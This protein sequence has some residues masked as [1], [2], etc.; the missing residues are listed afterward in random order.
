MPKS[1]ATDVEVSI[2]LPAYNEAEGLPHV[3]KNLWEALGK[4][5]EIIVIDDGSTDATATVAEQHFCRVVQHK[6][7]RGKG[8]A[9]RT[10]I[11]HAQGRYTIVM[12]ADGTY[13]ASAIPQII[14]LL[15]DCDMVR[16]RRQESR[17][18]IPRINRFG[19]WLFDR[20]LTLLHGLEGQDHLSGLY[21]FRREALEKLNLRSRGFDIEAEISVQASKKGLRVKTL[22]IRYQARFGEKKLR[23][24]RDGWVILNR[25]FAM[26][27]LY[28]PLLVFVVPSLLLLGVT[29]AGT[30][31]LSRGPFLITPYLGLS[32]HSFILA[33]L[34]V[35]GAFQLFS[36]G[37]T[38]SLYGVEFGYRVPKW[39]L[40]FSARHVR[41]AGVVLGL[42]LV[43]GGAIRLATMVYSWLRSGAGLYFNTHE[44]T[45]TATGIVWGLQ[46]TSTALFLS[47]F[48]GRLEGKR[49]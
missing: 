41:L 38:T 26:T 48:S 30:V 45:L 36:F 49:G 21:G 4:G 31:L 22:P 40:W 11:S 6:A 3:V 9:V 44:L 34:G 46:I 18:H 19:N 13:P 27:I 47:I 32:I 20:I 16:C 1:T 39:L 14:E 28:N 29:L 23:P 12:D 25:I 37:I 5:Y 2:L 7:N 15:K 10:G 35:L 24:W 17:Q 33:N 43:T 8:Y 42:L